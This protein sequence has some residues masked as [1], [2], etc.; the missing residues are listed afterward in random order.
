MRRVPIWIALVS[1]HAILLL[2]VVGTNIFHGTP[3]EA[4]GMTL[5][6]V[7]YLRLPV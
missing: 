3:M 2:L 1:V 6:A 7:P 4:L 5:L